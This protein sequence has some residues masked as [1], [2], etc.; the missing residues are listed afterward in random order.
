MATGAHYAGSCQCR[1]CSTIRAQN[2]AR[3]ERA[4]REAE[5]D[6]RLE[7]TEDW[8]PAYA[9]WRHGGYYVTNVRYPNGACGCVCR[10]NDGRWWIACDSRVLDEQES[11]PSRDAAARA[12][13]DLIAAGVLVSP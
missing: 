7:V 11:Y 5:E 3:Y 2:L 1:N 12:E 8:S 10:D 13:R 4:V 6:R 9:V